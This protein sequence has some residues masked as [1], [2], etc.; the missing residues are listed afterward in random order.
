MLGKRCTTELHPSPMFSPE[1]FAIS[2][3][4]FTEDCNQHVYQRL[5]DHRHL[6]EGRVP[7]SERSLRISW[8]HLCNSPHSCCAHFIC[9]PV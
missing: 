3:C 9:F 5:L 1:T 8:H 2:L 7:A 4:P 6:S